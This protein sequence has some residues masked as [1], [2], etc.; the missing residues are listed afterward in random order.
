MRIILNL[1][2]IHIQWNRVSFLVWMIESFMRITMKK[3]RVLHLGLNWVF[4]LQQTLVIHG[5]Y[6]TL[7]VNRQVVV[8][9]LHCIQYRIYGAIHTQLYATS[10][11]LISV[12]DSHTHSNVVNEMPTWLFI[13]LLT[14]DICNLFITI[15]QLV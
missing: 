14:N 6:T 4:Q 15:L 12:L 13:H 10:L 1:K 2:K 7:S 3:Y 5:I 8:D 11:Q 9:T